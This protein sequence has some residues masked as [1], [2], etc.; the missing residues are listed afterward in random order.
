MRTEKTWEH[1]NAAFEH[2]DRAFESANKAFDEAE[3]E[4]LFTKTNAA[5]LEPGGHHLRF[6]AK[7]WGERWKLFRKFIVLGFHALFLG[8]VEFR[9]VNKPKE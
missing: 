1:F 6:T 9:F 8:R 7:T 4:G 3:K 2:V 5:P